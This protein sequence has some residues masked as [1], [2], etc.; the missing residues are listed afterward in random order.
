VKITG[1]TL[2]GRMQ[3]SGSKRISVEGCCAA[4]LCGCRSQ[5]TVATYVVVQRDVLTIRGAAGGCDYAAA[6][7][8]SSFSLL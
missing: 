7:V 4:V 5:L 3:H 1:V 6:D 2:M 8:F